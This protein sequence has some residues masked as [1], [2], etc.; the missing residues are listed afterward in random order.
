MKQESAKHMVAWFKIAEFVSRGEK[1]RAL[2]LYRLLAHAIDDPAFVQQLEGDILLSFN[3][4]GAFEHYAVSAQLYAKQ[5]KTSE[6]AAVYE[7][8]ITLT[9]GSD[10][11]LETLINLYKQLPKVPRTYEATQLFLRNL[12]SRGA[13]EKVSF[14]L[15]QLDDAAV[16]FGMIHQELVAAWL[17]IENP[18][19][20]QL[21]HH[22]KKIIDFYFQAKQ[23][24]ALQTFLMTLKMLHALL[25]QEACFYMQ[26]N[27]AVAR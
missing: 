4:D 6:A 12:I 25:Y 21:K 26:D 17:N 1:E 27:S 14:A 9:P 24:K 2:A 22:V 15:Q 20:E 16:D 13:F 3:D 18:P 19:T 10:S 5:G 8:L 7:H 11:K 23:Q